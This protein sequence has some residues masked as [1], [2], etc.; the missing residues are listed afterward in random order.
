[1]F[2]VSV[3][4][5]NYNN[6]KY[7]STCL[8]SIISQTYPIKEIVVYDDCSTDGSREILTEFVAK[9][10]RIKVIYGQKNMGVSVARDTAIQNT[11]SDYICMLDADDY[12]YTNE[13]IENEM[14]TVQHVFS[15]TGKK[16]ISF[17]QTIDVDETGAAIGTVSSID[18]SGNERF[19]IVTRLYSNYMP[20]DYCFPKELYTKCGGYTKGLSL[21]EDWEL[22]IKFLDFT[23]FVYS[24]GYG[25]AYR[26]KAGGLSSVNYRKQLKT[27][28]QIFKRFDTS[29]KENIWFYGISMG[30]Y[31]KNMIRGN[32]R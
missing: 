26:H 8:N 25:T 4:V 19:K 24:G 32:K 17:S 21:F 22:N 23:D 3:I 10:K 11:T 5:P 28:I 7:L 16:V 14:K 15:E 9:D 6:E 1:M 31:L 29:L 18:L 12:F 27:K 30:A 20:R 2:S 13:K